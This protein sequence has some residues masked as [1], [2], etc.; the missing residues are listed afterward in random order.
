VSEITKI[1]DQKN[2]KRVNIFVD[3]A[4]F[5]GLHKETAVTFGLK[6]GKTVDEKWLKEVV[7]E[8][9]VKMAFEKAMDYLGI[10]MHTKKEL[11]EKLFKKGYQKEIIDRAIE[12]LEEYHYIDD[13]LFA[14]QFIEQNGKYSKKTLEN[15][16]KAKGVASD[17]IKTSLDD[18]EEDEELELC[19]SYAQKYAKIKDVSTQNGLQKLYA[20]L[21]RK[22]FS[23]ETIKKACKIALSNISDVEDIE[24]CD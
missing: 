3:E 24:I 17:I 5:C 18:R 15:K 6:I 16:L 20:S 21:M 23:F 2:K 19:V 12:R 10:R 9:E 8:S 11:F 22:G 1:E 13:S 4:F 7:F 14:R